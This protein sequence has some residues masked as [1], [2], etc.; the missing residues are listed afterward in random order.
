MRRHREMCG[1]WVM[2]R[3]TMCCQNA[4]S[5]CKV[6]SVYLDPPGMQNYSSKLKV[7]FFL[8][9]PPQ[10][11]RFV[12]FLPFHVLGCL[13]ECPW[14]S[15]ACNDRCFHSIDIINQ[16]YKIKWSCHQ[17]YTRQLPIPQ[18]IT[19]FQFSTLESAEPVGPEETFVE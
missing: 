19:L 1:Q 14:E 6:S 7:L 18:S 3:Q 5:Q 13:N 8:A 17:K 2:C 16:Q 12:L 4:S 9:F 11:G 15:L 10:K